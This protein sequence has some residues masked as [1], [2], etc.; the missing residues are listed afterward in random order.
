MKIREVKFPQSS[1]VRSEALIFRGRLAGKLADGSG[2]R[3]GHDG[4]IR[5]IVRAE[6]RND[7]LE[8]ESAPVLE[9]V[10]DIEFIDVPESWQTM[11]ISN[12]LSEIKLLA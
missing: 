7:L 4:D 10:R 2:S 12:F 3:L 11:F 5:C 1:L 6:E 9:R 8:G